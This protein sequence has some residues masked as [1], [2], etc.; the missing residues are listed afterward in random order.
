MAN[1][2]QNASS[3]IQAIASVVNLVIIVIFF[4][5]ERKELSRDMKTERREYWY[6]QTILSRGIE[7]VEKG[8]SEIEKLL[9]DIDRLDRYNVY[10]N[11]EDTVKGIIAKIKKQISIIKKV[12]LVY[13]KLFDDVLSKDI[14]FIF[15]NMEDTIICDIEVNFKAKLKNDSLFYEISDYKYKIYDRLYRYDTKVV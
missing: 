5:Y 1:I 3:I 10:T 9:S 6:R 12:L 8:F 11:H 14:K 13:T 2:I 7:D 4:I 15:E